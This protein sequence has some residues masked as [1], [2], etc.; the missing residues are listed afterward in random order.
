VPAALL[1]RDAA[2]FTLCDYDVAVA[3][4]CSRCFTALESASQLRFC[5][6]L[7]ESK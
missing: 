1:M 7:F 5:Q 3:A 4:E 6:I 2:A